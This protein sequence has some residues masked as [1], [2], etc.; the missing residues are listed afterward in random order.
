M[1]RAANLPGDASSGFAVAEPVEEDA[2]AEEV[3]A[4]QPV[5]EQA[6]AE[7]EPAPTDSPPAAENPPAAAAQQVA[8]APPPE[9]TPFS[10]ATDF[11]LP[12]GLSNFPFCVDPVRVPPEDLTTLTSEADVEKLPLADTRCGDGRSEASPLMWLS[13]APEVQG[14]AA[15]PPSPFMSFVQRLSSSAG[16]G[17]ILSIIFAGALFGLG[18]PFWFDVFTKLASLATQRNLAQLTTRVPAGDGAEKPVAIRPQNCV[19]EEQLVEAF[20]TSARSSGVAL[21]G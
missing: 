19:D 17:W 18:A 13:P 3:E 9:T 20:E 4:A 7:A 2:P 15:P 21:R 8:A 10:V 16:I 11:G 14:A 5:P 1:S 6:P 12:I